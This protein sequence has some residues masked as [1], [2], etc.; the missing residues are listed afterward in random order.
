[1]HL[2]SFPLQFN[3]ASLFNSAPCVDCCKKFGLERKKGKFSQL[4][5]TTKNKLNN[6][7]DSRNDFFSS[8]NRRKTQFRYFCTKTWNSLRSHLKTKKNHTIS[9]KNKSEY[10]KVNLFTKTSSTRLNRNTASD[11]SMLDDVSRLNLDTEKF[12]TYRKNASRTKH[13]HLLLYA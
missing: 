11:L 10:E 8:K 2:K 9:C 6:E 5:P 1:M 13:R 12:S 4:K 3:V 7:R